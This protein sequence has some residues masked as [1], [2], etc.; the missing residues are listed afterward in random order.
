M[1]S[2]LPRKRKCPRAEGHATGVVL[3]ALSGLS[4]VQAHGERITLFILLEGN[5]KITQLLNAKLEL[6]TSSL[7][8]HST[9]CLMEE[10]WS[11][12]RSDFRLVHI[13]FGKWS[14][15]THLSD[16]DLLIEFSE[17]R[18]I[19]QFWPQQFSQFTVIPDSWGNKFQAWKLPCMPKTSQSVISIVLFPSQFYKCLFS[20]LSQSLVLWLNGW[21]ARC[22][23]WSPGEETMSH[24]QNY[25]NANQGGVW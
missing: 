16:S 12:I 21:T 18:K 25:L 1:L 19:L 17:V 2:L 24:Y 11:P 9:A 20:S 15:N 6:G 3:M 22:W 13:L 23:K 7:Q 8:P 14:G 5:L 10:N 4:L